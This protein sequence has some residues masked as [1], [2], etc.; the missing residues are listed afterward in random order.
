MESMKRTLVEQE[1]TCWTSGSDVW[2]FLRW[3]MYN[4]CVTKCKNLRMLAG[5]NGASHN[6]N[7]LMLNGDDW[8]QAS[9]SKDRQLSIF[10]TSFNSFPEHSF[11]SLSSIA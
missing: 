6:Q 1:G 4:F 5:N 10:M 3:V 2:D 7:F 11:P 8:V 9:H